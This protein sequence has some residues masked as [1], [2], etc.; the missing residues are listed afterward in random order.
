MNES[1]R[2]R[3]I[4]QRLAPS[5]E[6]LA[7]MAAPLRRRV[8]SM[9]RLAPGE[10]VLDIG[11]GTGASFPAL[12]RAVGQTGRVVGVDLTP[13]M[14]D[15]ARA[16]VARR[17]WNNVD[18]IEGAVGEVDL[19]EAH[20]ALFCL[21][22]WALQDAAALQRV[23]GQ[24]HSDGLVAALA[25][26]L[27]PRWNVPSRAWV[28]LVSPRLGVT[29]ENLDRPWLAL[30]ELVPNLKVRSTGLGAFFYAWGSV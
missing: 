9:L 27:A 22:P 11:C 13:A 25:E 7:L 4:Y 28:R 8:I 23:I 3:G 17:R 6:P 18:L 29:R 2:I 15:R 21:V 26:K 12:V 10:T 5:Y 24:L 20:A 1:D 16:R 19:P 14:L 30:A